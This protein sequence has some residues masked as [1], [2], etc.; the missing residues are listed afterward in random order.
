MVNLPPLTSRMQ[1]VDPKTGLVTAQAVDFWQQLTS[2]ISNNG[3]AGG[4]VNTVTLSGAITGEISGKNLIL[5]APGVA[6]EGE[7][8]T[9][10]IAGT[11]TT[12]TLS[13]GALTIEASGSGGASFTGTYRNE[14]SSR[15]FNTVYTN[16][17]AGVMEIKVTAQ[18]DQNGVFILIND[19]EVD[20][21]FNTSGPFV[22][23]VSA[24]ANPGD[25]YEVSYLGTGTPTLVYWFERY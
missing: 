6:Y 17:Q 15:A 18:M 13:A 5:N 24:F 16:T 12:M 23:S 4:G 10:I 11:G 7:P 22:E 3:N 1:F 14:T 9:S 21:T 2:A 19:V 20:Y 8:V 25:T